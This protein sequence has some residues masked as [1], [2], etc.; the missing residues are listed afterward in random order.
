[1]RI[2]LMVLLFTLPLTAKEILLNESNTLSLRGPVTSSSI[3]DLSVNLNRLNSI[4]TGEP[5]Y[6]VMNTPGGSVYAGF[7]FIRLAETSKRKINTITIQAASM[8]FHIVEA[9]SGDRL[10]LSYSTLM[11]HKASGGFNGEFP[12]QL[13]SRLAH[14]MSHIVEADK[15]VVARTK[16][17]QTMESYS[18]LIQNEYWANGSKAIKDG[19]ADDIVTA[20]CSDELL[21]G[22]STIQFATMFGNVDVSF[23]K[24]PLITSPLKVES[25]SDK[26]GYSIWR[27]ISDTSNISKLLI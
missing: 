5:I 18:N 23:S 26:D 24:C 27:E 13:N 7:D 21:N 6:L 1:M 20:R 4:E 16:G 17:K 14:V 22:S 25:D 9:M 10:M 11:S 15:S 19:F 8:G 12:G 2:I 3:G